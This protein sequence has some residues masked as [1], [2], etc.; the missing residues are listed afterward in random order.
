MIDPEVVAQLV[1]RPRAAR[2]TRTIFRK[3]GLD[4]AGDDNRRV[5]AVLTYL[6]S[7]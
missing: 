5:L 4:A 3:L 7:G 6:R 2:H 1:H